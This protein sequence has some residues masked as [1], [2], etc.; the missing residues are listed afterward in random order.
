MVTVCPA[1]TWRPSPFTSDCE[2]SSLGTSKSSSMVISGSP[3]ASKD[4][5]GKSSRGSTSSP[6]TREGRTSRTTT[7]PGVN[8]SRSEER[9]V[10]KEHRGSGPRRHTRWPRDWSS[11]VCSSDLS[12]TFYQ[13][14]RNEFTGNFQILI[15]GYF[16]FA[17]R[18]ERYGRQ[19]I[20]RL[21]LFTGNPGGKNIK[22]DD[23]AGG[24]FICGGWFLQ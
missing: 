24:Q 21:N 16:R 13:R 22:D 7:R 6:A 1:R 3:S 4:T 14:L 5:E 20:A 12:L 15:N 8:S 2:T 11:D 10:G 19:I 9:R 23:P 18:F 17:I